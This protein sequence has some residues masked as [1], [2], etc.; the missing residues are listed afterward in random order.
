MKN[1]VFKNLTILALGIIFLIIAENQS[2]N[3]NSIFKYVTVDGFD[4][5][6]NSKN[7]S[8]NNTIHFEN[9]NDSSSSSISQQNLTKVKWPTV[10]SEICGFSL[11]YPTSAD[12]KKKT[13]RFDRSFVL[14]IEYP[15]Y[16]N[17]TLPINLSVDCY[18]NN[19]PA[20]TNENIYEMVKND[21]NSFSSRHPNV[22]LVEDPNDTKWSVGGNKTVSDIEGKE[23][24]GNITI[25]DETFT[26]VKRR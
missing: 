3:L 20:Y 24:P 15:Y 7:R 13:N 16:P 21:T 5:S 17:A 1:Y 4:E 9:E 11:D 14:N 8:S 23:L 25:G 19:N 26:F 2:N 6:N 18:A 10:K 22:F 12:V